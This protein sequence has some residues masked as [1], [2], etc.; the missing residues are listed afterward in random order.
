MGLAEHILQVLDFY[1][2]AS[3]QAR[4]SDDGQRAKDLIQKLAN[5]NDAEEADALTTVVEFA[6]SMAADNEDEDARAV[7]EIVQEF[8]E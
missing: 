2:G 7:R 3:S 4:L 5:P 8:A 1:D 6:E